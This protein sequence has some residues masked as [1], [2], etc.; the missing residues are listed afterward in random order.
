MKT[1]FNSL[2]VAFTVSLVTVSASFAETNPG[3]QTAPAAT[4]KTGIYTNRAGNLNIALDKETKGSVS[5]KLKN[6]AG[7]VL[8]D[9]YL[10]K[11]EKS[12]RI[13][14]NMN[15]L[16]DGTYQLEISNGVDTSTQTV[17]LAT[18][19]PSSPSRLVAIN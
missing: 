18:K 3:K 12:T 2:L 8:F 17:T 11:N 9:Q 16:P 1:L 15:E 6:T 5:I 19:L 7:K 14:L 10:G 13:S 4:Y